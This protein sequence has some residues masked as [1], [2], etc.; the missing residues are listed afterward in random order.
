MRYIQI[1]SAD[2]VAN[3]LYDEIKAALQANKTVTW[4]LSGGSCLPIEL[5]IAKSLVG[6]K[7]PLQNLHTSLMDERYGAPGHSN[8]NWWQLEQA[9]FPLEKIPVYRVLQPELDLRAAARQFARTLENLF[10]DSDVILGLFGMGADGHTA[11]IKPHAFDMET[12]AY[13]ASYTGED[14]ERITITPHAIGHVA[15]AVV[16]VSGK[17]KRPA[18]Q[19]LLEEELP[20]TDQP[21]QLLK[22]LPVCTL[23]TDLEIKGETS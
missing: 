23:F 17:A 21:A 5:A 13:A 6:T 9:G 15:D 12:S 10:N 18:L 2:T 4:L 8:E 7:L 20:I 3:Y 11:G 19:R 22:H 16:Y 14:F 1:T